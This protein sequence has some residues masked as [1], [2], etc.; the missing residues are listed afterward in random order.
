MVLAWAQAWVW[1]WARV[2]A[3]EHEDQG[4]TYVLQELRMVVAK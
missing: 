1:A 2:R 3:E 4:A